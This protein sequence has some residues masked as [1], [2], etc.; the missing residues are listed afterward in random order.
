MM[1]DAAARKIR[2]RGG[3]VLMGRELTGL[4]FDRNHNLWRID[5][6]TADGGRETY[7]ARHVVSSAPIRELMDKIAPRPISVSLPSIF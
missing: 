6:S 5:V 2:Q 7:T 3:K 4:A 1:W